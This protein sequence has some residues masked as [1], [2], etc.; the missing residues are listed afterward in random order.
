MYVSEMI[1]VGNHQQSESAVIFK[2]T[3]EKDFWE[4][5]NKGQVLM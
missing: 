1:K 4:K 2:C 5:Q 3:E